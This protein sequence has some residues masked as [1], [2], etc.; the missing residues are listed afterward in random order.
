MNEKQKSQGLYAQEDAFFRKEVL[1]IL[2]IEDIQKEQHYEFGLS[3]RE[4]T[5]RSA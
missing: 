2:K 5:G 4:D 1:M 3:I